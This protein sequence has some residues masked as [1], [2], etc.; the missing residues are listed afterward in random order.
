MAKQ[1]AIILSGCG[2]K[3]GS[4]IHESVL[5]LLHVVKQGAVPSFFAPNENQP[6]VINHVTGAA[7][8]E[9]RN[10]MVEAARIA[11]GEIKDIKQAKAADFDALLIP[12][13]FGAANNLCNFGS[14]GEVCEVH[15]EVAR[16]C[17]EFHRAKKPIGAICIAPVIVSRVFGAEKPKLTIGTDVGVAAKL[18]KLGVQHV[19]CAATEHVVDKD[20]KIVT[21]PAYMLGKNI[22]EVD[23][24]IA[25]L[26]IDVLA[27]A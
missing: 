5:A 16:V 2:V 3:D 8:G 15:P 9:A 13:G 21:T 18:Q 22:A 19:N 26:V 7:G 27:L 25:R 14:K 10:M 23:A 12:G 24:G 4:E 20:K 1:V 11:R 6:Q 17:Q